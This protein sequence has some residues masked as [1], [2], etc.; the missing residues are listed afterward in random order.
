MFLETWDTFKH[1]IHASRDA[2]KSRERGPPLI[3]HKEHAAGSCLAY[4]R[5]TSLH[6]R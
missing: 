2:G 5:P 1:S 4:V 6:Y 3:A